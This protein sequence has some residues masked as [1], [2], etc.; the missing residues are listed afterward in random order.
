MLS[1]GSQF[2]EINVGF[3]L[4]LFIVAILFSL[5]TVQLRKQYFLLFLLIF[6]TVVGAKRFAYL[7]LQIG[8]IPLYITEITIAIVVLSLLLRGFLKGKVKIPGSLLNKI[9][10]FYYLIG[11]L[12]LFR[13]LHY[14]IE[15]IRDSALVY[16]SIFYFFTI[17]VIKNFTILKNFFII[18]FIASIL[19]TIYFY[20]GYFNIIPWAPQ[21]AANSMYLGISLILLYVLLP[22]IKKQSLRNIIYIIMLLQLISI[23]LFEVRSVW[24][25]LLISFL[26][27]SILLFKN[28]LFKVKHLKF[29]S[30]GTSLVIF[31]L[32]ALLV[33][34]PPVTK[35]AL[36]VRTVILPTKRVPGSPS[37]G[38]TLF[39]LAMWRELLQEVTSRP[40][41]LILG[42]GFGK[43]FM[44]K[45]AAFMHREWMDPHNSHLAILYRM[46][47]LGF[48]IYIWLILRFLKDCLSFLKQNNDK[49][50]KLYIIGLLGAFILVLVHCT[51]SV[52]LEGPYKGIFFWITMGLCIVVIKLA[53]NNHKNKISMNKTRNFNNNG[54][55]DTSEK[56]I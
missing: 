53:N 12:A 47:L 32:V 14:G 51:F 46:G 39:R 26:F 31:M 7:H 20:L 15:S 21:G 11:I 9:Y 49:T 19:A 28:R 2:S 25:A 45:C 29:W 18:F 24:I 5:F 22:L 4:T 1:I 55:S 33:G 40:D 30:L 16:Y 3:F 42:V 35:V 54:G 48:G 27:V 52:I 6:G 44:P 43:P 13:G 17:Y 56:R 50:T 8:N 41:Y 10:F 23:A 38:N 36:E 37:V 34:Y